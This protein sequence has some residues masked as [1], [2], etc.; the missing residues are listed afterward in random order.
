MGIAVSDTGP[1]NYLV[2]IEQIDVLPRLFD[3]VTIPKSVEAE[4]L[5]A[6]APDTVRLWISAPPPWLRVDPATA[7]AVSSAGSLDDGERDTI[8]LATAI[9]A[10]LILMD[11]RAGVAVARNMGLS[12]TGTLGLLILGSQ[13]G[14][15][16][17]E[18]AFNRL[19]ATNFH[20]RSELLNDLVAAHHA[21]ARDV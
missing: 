11:E 8:T 21:R 16:S 17:L 20:C 13:R 6:K 3:A 14:L 12:V 2:L 5:R 19:R 15:L 1:L 7:A 9:N 18:D 4:L 10:D